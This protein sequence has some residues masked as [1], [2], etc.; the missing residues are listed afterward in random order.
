MRNYLL[1]A[2]CVRH[3]LLRFFK[4]V[5]PGKV[6]GKLLAGGVNLLFLNITTRPFCLWGVLDK[7]SY[8]H[9]QGRVNALPF[10][11]VWVFF[12]YVLVFCK[13]AQFPSCFVPLGMRLR[14][15]MHDITVAG[16]PA[17]EEL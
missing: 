15:V 5:W 13:F 10:V 6:S 9:I 12:L 3:P 11:G 8:I 4:K 17:E 1:P 14:I 2:Q 16:Q 7:P